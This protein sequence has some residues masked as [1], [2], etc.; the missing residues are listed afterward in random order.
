MTDDHRT[1]PTD[2][3]PDVTIIVAAFDAMPYVTRCI[4]SVFAQT[5][6]IDRIEIV[7][8][9]DGS[10]DGTGAEL[11]RL[12]AQCPTM[13]VVHQENSG[14]P[15][16]PRN[17]ALGLATGRF[18]FF[19]DADD[20]LGAE[21]MERMVAA[22]DENHSD[23]VLGR[24]VGVGGRKAP[25]SI[26]RVNQPRAD[27]F[28]SRVYWSL[29]PMKLFRRQHLENLGL[30][31]AT[32]LPWGED[33]PFVTE[34]Y[35][36]AS[37][38]SIV[39]DYDC[40]YLTYRD[41][42]N[43]FTKRI[44]SAA[45]RLQGPTRMLE[46]IAKYV[47]PG[48]NR[49]Y[50]MGRIFQLEV[51]NILPRL[52][53]EP[54]PV[55]Q[56]AGFEVVKSWVDRWYTK[57][58]AYRLSPLHRIAINLMKRGMMEEALAL[59]PEWPPARPWNV[60]VDGNRVFADYPYFR[61]RALGVP[62]D[63][64]EIT[65]RLKAHCHIDDIARSDGAVS[66]TGYGFIDFIETVGMQVHAVLRRRGGGAEY[67]VP[68]TLLTREGF[69]TE[70]W[71]R[72]ILRE[73]SGFEV[74]IDPATAANGQ[75]LP[76]G[77]WD[78]ALRIASEGVTREAAFGS[79]VCA[80]K[81]GVPEFG[82]LFCRQVDADPVAPGAESPVLAESVT[83]VADRPATLR[84]AGRCDPTLDAPSSLSLALLRRDGAEKRLDVEVVDGRFE[85]QLPLRSMEKGRPLHDGTWDAVLER[86][87]GDTSQIFSIPASAHLRTLFG[88][89]GLWPI[90]TRIV[91]PAARLVVTTEK[92][93]PR[94]VLRHG[95][96]LAKL[97][98][99]VF[100]FRG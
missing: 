71:N 69:G 12:A 37:V 57:P 100:G 54:D 5:L 40:V 50:L 58:I 83:W 67:A 90:R 48:R 56:R 16:Q 25:R 85:I 96:R 46:M 74:R 3:T 97:A 33:M 19:L 77:T 94:R 86:R 99:S 1:T 65:R 35:L 60:I 34:S 14:S 41:D 42:G 10:G 20:Y 47:G 81:A 75:K 32:D 7:A 2:G 84:I 26:F 17:V 92:I 78:V 38:I 95:R 88:W 64:Y 61:D 8:V 30:R 53:A 72:K 82:E 76:A 63:C 13:H 24:L 18:V 36:N 45:S 73:N 39:A 52:A 87:M 27:L 6:G 80:V 62:D 44:T 28:K 89:R 31:F 68:A 21:A 15:A 22:A 93:E 23:M 91:T 29:N 55:A 4:D 9:D 59:F 70:E 79:L 98:R 11:D 43:N 66:L 51:I 49:D